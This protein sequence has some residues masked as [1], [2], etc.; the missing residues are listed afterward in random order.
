M[1]C[2]AS[3]GGSGVLRLTLYSCPSTNARKAL[4]CRADI[5]SS[6][7]LRAYPFAI[8]RDAYAPGEA[9]RRV[10]LAPGRFLAG[11]LAAPV[12]RRARVS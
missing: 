3:N 2:G 4:S 11:A 7:T 1:Y 12:A 8:I 6:F 10:P 5:T 9:F